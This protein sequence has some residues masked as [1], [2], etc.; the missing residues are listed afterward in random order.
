MSHSNIVQTFKLLHSVSLPLWDIVYITLPSCNWIFSTAESIQLGYT[1][2]FVVVVVV[3]G[4]G[5]GSSIDIDVVKKF[6]LMIVVVACVVRKSLDALV[7]VVIFLDF[8][9]MFANLFLA[10]ECTVW[11]CNKN[12]L[13]YVFIYTSIYV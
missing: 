13:M 11:S 1:S 6:V 7:E 2:H 10:L 9:F 3:G 12:N 8:D 4:G 5:G